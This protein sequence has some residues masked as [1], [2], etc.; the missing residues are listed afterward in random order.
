MTF[1]PFCRPPTFARCC[2]VFK[3]CLCPAL[4]YGFALKGKSNMAQKLEVCQSI[5]A[6]EQRRPDGFEWSMEE[7]FRKV[8]EAGL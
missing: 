3:P 6:M 1:A 5:W 2:S 7:K 8:A 4:A